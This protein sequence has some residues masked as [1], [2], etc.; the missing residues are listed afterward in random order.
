MADVVATDFVKATSKFILNWV[1]VGDDPA[2][3]EY[4]ELLKDFSEYGRCSFEEAHG[5]LYRL[6]ER[7][8]GIQY[9]P[10]TYRDR[11]TII[12]KTIKED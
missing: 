11:G 3:Q 9:H 5:D 1:V 10:F 4:L 8:W 6:V 7:L 2:E 12:W